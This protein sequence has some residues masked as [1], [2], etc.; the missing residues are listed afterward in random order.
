MIVTKAKRR[1]NRYSINIVLVSQL[2][3]PQLVNDLNNQND[4]WRNTYHC[5]SIT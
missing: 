1:K 4:M 3:K 2:L 5:Y